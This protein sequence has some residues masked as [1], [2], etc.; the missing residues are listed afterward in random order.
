MP[1]PFAWTC[2]TYLQSVSSGCWWFTRHDE[3]WRDTVGRERGVS[4]AK[5][6]R[7]APVKD[8]RHPNSGEPRRAC[9]A[10]SPYQWRCHAALMSTSQGQ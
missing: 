4:G 9:F 10:Q 2:E 1:E 3:G 6:R 8:T 5:P 7:I